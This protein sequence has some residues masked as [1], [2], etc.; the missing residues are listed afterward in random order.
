MRTG[1]NPGEGGTTVAVGESLSICLIPVNSLADNYCEGESDARQIAM[2]TRGMLIPPWHGSHAVVHVGI[3]R[4]R[5]LTPRR[6][7][8]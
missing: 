2:H 4:S 7:K 1:T 3:F 8:S 6:R 5:M